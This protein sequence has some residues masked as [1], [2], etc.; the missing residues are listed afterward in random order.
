MKDVKPK[1][2]KVEVIKKIMLLQRTKGLG[3][4]IVRSKFGHF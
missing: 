4:Q 1:S 3:N 2:K